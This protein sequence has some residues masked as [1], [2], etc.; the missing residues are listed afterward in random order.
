MRNPFD[1]A[2]FASM[3]SKSGTKVLLRSLLN[4]FAV[5]DAIGV[6]AAATGV[7]LDALGAVG[8]DAAATGVVRDA[9]HSIGVDGAA[10]FAS[11]PEA[12]RATASF[13]TCLGH[14]SDPSSPAFRE[15]DTCN[16]RTCVRVEED[17][18]RRRRCRRRLPRFP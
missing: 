15:R 18:E 13:F 16:L 12:T 3:S 5:L 8:V 11:T 4:L 9:M 1:E 17:D 6:D 2:I 14:T 10:T 7:V